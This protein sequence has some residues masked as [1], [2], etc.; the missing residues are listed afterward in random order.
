MTFSSSNLSL[1][2][3]SPPSRLILYLPKELI[4]CRFVSSS[5]GVRCP[6]ES[7][8]FSLTCLLVEVDYSLF[9]V[10]LLFL[11]VFLIRIALASILAN[12][13]SSLLFLPVMFSPLPL[14]I[15]LLACSDII[16]GASPIYLYSI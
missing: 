7:S 8:F 16:F 10:I 11:F 13:D 3:M 9:L 15:N 1:K 12:G 2:L 5:G 6:S 14:V 4:P